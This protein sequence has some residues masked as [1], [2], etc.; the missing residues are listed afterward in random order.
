MISRT[1][2]L[3]VV[4]LGILAI[5][6]MPG[7][8]RAQEDK[9]GGLQ[10]FKFEASDPDPWGFKD[11]WRHYSLEVPFALQLRLNRAQVSDTTFLS[12]RPQYVIRLY[13]LPRNRFLYRFDLVHEVMLI[14]ALAPRR[15]GIYGGNEVLRFD[16][17]PIGRDKST[18]LYFEGGAGICQFNEHIRE[19]TGKF[20]F[21]LQ[22]GFGFKR[23]IKGSRTA[24]GFGFGMDHFSDNGI[25]RPNQGINQLRASFSMDRLPRQ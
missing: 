15:A 2:R 21:S 12:F 22:A 11:R 4:F 8:A 18:L 10:P 1:V 6:I 25:H 7:K 23:R 20:Q 19:L 3:F 16:F 24:Y 5:G 13:D 14:A 9:T 17:N